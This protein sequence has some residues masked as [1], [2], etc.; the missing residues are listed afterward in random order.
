MNLREKQYNNLLKVLHPEEKYQTISQ[1]NWKILIFDKDCH[2]II[3][4]LFTLMDLR[5]NG[6]TLH[7]QI[8][9]ER[10]LIQ[11]SPTIYFCRPTKKNINIIIGDC[12]KGIYD[13]LYLNFTPSISRENLE[14]LA[15]GLLETDSTQ[16]I[17]KIIDHYLNYI[18]Y[19]ETFFTLNIKNSYYKLQ[20]DNQNESK[21][22]KTIN[23]I[24]EGLF[25]VLVT[26]KVIPI[27]RCPPNGAAA[28][29]AKELNKKIYEHLKQPRNLFQEETPLS[30]VN[31]QRITLII[32]DRDIDF[33]V[34]LHHSWIYHSLIY[35]VLETS[36]N[37]VTVDVDLEAKTNE[38]SNENSNEKPKENSNENSFK[39]NNKKTFYIHED[40]DFWK[41]NHFKPFPDIGDQISILT[42]EF[43][44]N[45]ANITEP[46]LNLDVMQN[47]QNLSSKVSNLPQLQKRKKEID[48]H[49]SIATGILEQIQQRDLGTFFDVEQAVMGSSSTSS[50]EFQDVLKLLRNPKGSSFDKLRL[51]LIYFISK[52][53][54]KEDDLNVLL[55][56]LE[57]QNIEYQSY[58]NHF[59]E[60]KMLQKKQ[61][62]MNANS[63]SKNNNIFRD[64]AQKFGLHEMLPK[65]YELPI[66]RV[67]SSIMNVKQDTK[68]ANYFFDYLDPK[69]MPKYQT[70]FK[71]AI[72]FVVGGGNPSEFINLKQFS[73]SQQMKRNIIY[74]S[75]EIINA[76]EFLNQ[77][78]LKIGNDEK[79]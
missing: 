11:D 3:S 52:Q 79:I 46:D 69:K 49:T 15:R 32:L 65:R 13:S 35:D 41:D 60:L 28:F 25:G 68:S 2:Q 72:V 26:L 76:Q 42:K 34:M 5:K 67:V 70:P 33:N 17:N 4:S 75:T 1:S 58:Y 19:E 7:L 51:F 43:Q 10:H 18:T 29:V 23:Q 16:K 14:Q 12:S 59:N 44:E 40:D 38:N 9:L 78:S 22:T 64:I 24:V 27:I 45:K 53:T 63:R 57:E 74:G 48:K 36:L 20:V 30:V 56:T 55:K 62:Q 61:M 39:K 50:N 77:L 47:A 6:I 21:I 8:N 71:S 73:D 37:Q 66:T 54:I 31:F